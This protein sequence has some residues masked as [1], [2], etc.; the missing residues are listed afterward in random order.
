MQFG[1]CFSSLYDDGYNSKEVEL[2]IGEYI[3]K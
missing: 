1:I 3:E 2:E